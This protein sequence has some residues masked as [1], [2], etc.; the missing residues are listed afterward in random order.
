[1]TAL[2][3]R[4]GQGTGKG[5]WGRLMCEIFGQHGIHISSHHQLTGKFNKHLLDCA[6]LFA[7]EAFWPGDKSSEGTLKR[8]VTEDTLMIEPKFF[9]A[10]MNKNRLHII[11][12]SNMNWVVPVA[13]DDRRFVETDVL[14][15]YRND[16]NYFQPL[17]QE[18][19]NGGGAAMLH[20]LL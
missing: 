15:K 6:V 19:Q 14:E 13:I 4:G 3:F 16:K 20:D 7:D 18:I 5:V 11:I 2:V 17:Y 12:A 1:E 8:I 10:T 9:D